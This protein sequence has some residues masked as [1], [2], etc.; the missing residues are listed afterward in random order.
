MNYDI[1]L[2]S[3]PKLLPNGPLLS[4]AQLNSV[5]K[6]SGFSSKFLDFNAWLYQKTNNTE[7]SY[8]W[9]VTDFTFIDPKLFKDKFEKKFNNLIDEYFTQFILPLNPK[10]VGLSS[11]SYFSWMSV[12]SICSRIKKINPNIKILLGGPS[13]SQ[14]TIK[15]SSFILRLKHSRLINDYITGDAEISIIEYLKGNLNF[16]GINNHNYDNSFNRNEI[17]TPDYSDIDFS[18]YKN[19]RLSIS[20]S[21]GCV[22]SCAF[23]NVPSIWPKF[24][25]KSGKK[26]ATEI[27]ELYEKY[28][29][30]E[31]HNFLFVDSLMNGNMKEFNSMIQILSEYKNK[32]GAQFF[33]GGQYI[34]RENV[35][36]N[37]K[38]FDNLYQSG[39]H[40][41]TVGVETGSER[42]R[43]EIGKPFTNKSIETHLQ[44]FRRVG[45][46]MTALMLVGFPTETDNDFK[47]SLD[48]LDLFYSYKDVVTEIAVDTPMVVIPGTPVYNEWE[49]FGIH[50]D[51]RNSQYEWVSDSNDYKK[52]LER[53]FL[54][55]NKAKQLN[56]YQKPTV[57]GKTIAAS[58]EYLIKFDNLN[59]EVVDIIKNNFL[60]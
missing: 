16:P 5:I 40:F 11:L 25:N 38:F 22:R 35:K 15:T 7:F 13:I 27:I 49:K 6:H 4:L 60:D 58:K 8:I 47:Y 28:F 41:V 26:V 37:D 55:L 59:Q 48:I 3:V 34:F 54:F 30:P 19:L 45:I 42:L 14:K 1:V 2:L 18:L 57:S 46:K 33:Y 32:T 53:F 21:R 50:F 17:P 10:I 31:P 24:I 52:R 39:C 44:E 43:Y 56:L 36:L 51:T 9:D 23:C 20:G 12:T 29:S